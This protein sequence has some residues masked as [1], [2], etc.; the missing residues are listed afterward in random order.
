MG[1]VIDPLQ[2]DASSY[3][4]SLQKRVQRLELAAAQTTLLSPSHNEPVSTSPGWDSANVGAQADEQ[5]ATQSH[6]QSQGETLETTKQVLDYLPLSA[7]AE[8]RDRQETS[9]QHYSFQ[10]FLDA[11]SSV[12]GSDPTRS[13]I[14]NVALVSSV[15]AFYQA[16][17]PSSL[18]L[19][20]SVADVPI[21]RYLSLCEVICP[22]VERQGFLAK[23]TQVIDGLEVSETIASSPNGAAQRSTT[24]HLSQAP[25]DIL[26]V[27]IG[28]ATGI[29]VSP[30][31]RHKESISVMLAQTALRLVPR[32]LSESDN[33]AIVRSLIALAIYSTYST[34]GGSTWHLM[35][36]AL[37]RA[38]SAGMHT[39]GL[40]DC[41]ALEAETRESGRLFWALYALD[42]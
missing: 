25:H 17:L 20:R 15:E 3:I 12:S 35:G 1:V 4:E 36:L 14:S 33:A 7:M 41:R 16:V 26:L 31:H 9:L 34:L 27:Y 24:T 19:S 5:P 30:D 28:T 11:A 29:L 13:D 32:V 38:M 40:S 39:E 8:L 37:A 2:P 6:S 10:T 22:F 18:R 21:Q 42:A 23:Y